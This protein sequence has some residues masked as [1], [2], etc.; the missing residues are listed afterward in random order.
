MGKEFIVD[1]AFC[2]C[3]FGT[4]P[5]RLKVSNHQLA[6]MNG[7][8]PTATTLSLGNTFYPPG[9]AVCR[10]SPLTPKPCT[11]A[12]IQWSNA[13][14]KLEISVGGYALTDKSKGTCAS[15]CPNCI[16]ITM[17]GQLD[18]PGIGQ[19]ENATSI[20]QNEMD[21]LGESVALT[22]HQVDTLLDIQ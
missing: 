15:G 7:D 18:L 4:A 2:M 5:A 3:K 6:Y 19:M 16:S 13:Y 22:D 8:K 14:K 17:T 10:V 9:F 21:P 1:G 11:P 20:L 12:I